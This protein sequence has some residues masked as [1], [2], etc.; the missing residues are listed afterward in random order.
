MPGRST[1][2]VTQIMKLR[3]DM[4]PL[5]TVMTLLLKSATQPN[6]EWRGGKEVLTSRK[7]TKIQSMQ[8]GVVGGAM[9][10]DQGTPRD[11]CHTL[12]PWLLLTHLTVTAQA[13]SLLASVT[14]QSPS[15]HLFLPLTRVAIV[16]PLKQT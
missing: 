11:T 14:T 3:T 4:M 5:R 1:Q 12:L 16:I 8:A 15:L 9:N 6:P 2:P 10:R 7:R 13:I